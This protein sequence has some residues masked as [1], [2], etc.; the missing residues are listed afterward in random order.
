MIVHVHSMI[1]DMTRAWRN[2]ARVALGV[3]LLSVTLLA[4]GCVK[5]VERDDARMSTTPEQQR[6]ALPPSSRLRQRRRLPPSSRSRILRSRLRPRR[7][8]RPPN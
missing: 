2:F 3:T 7:P 1:C 8:T 4:S 5:P 6:R